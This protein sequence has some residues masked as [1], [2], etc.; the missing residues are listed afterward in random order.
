MSRF[1]TGFFVAV[2]L[3]AS[4]CGGG[5]AGGGS[6][7]ARSTAQMGSAILSFVIPS[8]A[9]AATA[10]RS[11]HGMYI[12]PSTES[13]SVTVNGGAPQITNVGATSPNCTSGSTGVTCTITISAPYGDD[14][15]V[16]TLY[17]GQNA[18]G[19]AVGTVTVTGQ[20]SAGAAFMIN[21]TVAS[22]LQ[23]VAIYVSDAN[24][25]NAIARFSANAS[26]AA[27]PTMVQSGGAQPWSIAFDSSGNMYVLFF[28]YPP[29]GGA[30]AMYAYDPTTQTYAATPTLL[31]GSATQLTAP[32]A[33]W[34]NNNRMYIT[35]E[36]GNVVVFPTSATGNVAPSL[37][38]NGFTNNV[39]DPSYVVTDPA[40]T[41]VYVAN[42]YAPPY[43]IQEF[44][45][46]N[47][48]FIGSITGTSTGGAFTS[49]NEP[50]GLAVDTSGNLY[51]GSSNKVLVFAPGASGNAPLLRSFT[52]STGG[53]INAIALDNNGNLFATQSTGSVGTFAAYPASASGSVTA[54]ASMSYQQFFAYFNSGDIAV[55]PSG[56]VW[57]GNPLGNAITAYQVTGSPGAATFGSILQ[58]MQLGTVALQRPD[59]MAF[60]NSGNLWVV[61]QSEASIVEL[62]STASGTPTPLKT[63]TSL[64]NLRNP[65]GLAFDSA[66]N[67]WVSDRSMGRPA[68]Y[69]FAATAT[70]NVSPIASILG[71]N[72]GLSRPDQIAIDHSNNIYVANR[73]G[74]NVLIFASGSSGNVAPT[75]TLGGSNTMITLPTGIALDSQGNIY[76][77][78][79]STTGASI[80]VFAPGSTGNVAPLRNIAGSSTLLNACDTSVNPYY[81][82]CRTQIAVDSAQNIYVGTLGT[83]PTQVLVFSPSANGNAEPFRTITLSGSILF[84]SSIAISPTQ[85]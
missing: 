20:V 45:A 70:G 51:V 71:T 13:V 24:Y 3:A 25:S 11:R 26:G 39:T 72:T 67:L 81:T 7:A 63:I 4:G 1:Y 56:N 40:G 12:D 9:N 17:N 37:T 85:P 6:G 65:S 42:S 2:V 82:N 48:Q 68:L 78:S 21:A 66:G 43:S 44:S 53:G 75:A 14:T 79:S 41:T 23:S 28:D 64:A 5:G 30:V 80:Q 83:P 50:N 47:G 35:L 36:S 10:G 19:T 60:D 84:S 32:C 57:V 69:K 77:K 8:S 16:V 76:V 15:F 22:T 62:S 74:G 18:T 73:V 38:I 27:T 46:S 29:V 54:S 49:S 34:I 61:N 31:A 33:I 55:D 52:A 59:Q 58:N